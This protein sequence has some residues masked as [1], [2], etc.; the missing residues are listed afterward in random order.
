MIVLK[1][2]GKFQPVTVSVAGGVMHNVG[3]IL[4]A[5]AIMQTSAIAW[6]LLVLW[7]SGIAAGAAVGLLGS[8]MLRRLPELR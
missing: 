4:V 2:T 5:M 1:K 8:W 7:V 3:Q 6:Y